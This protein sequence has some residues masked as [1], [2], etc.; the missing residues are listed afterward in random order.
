MTMAAVIC[1]HLM[2][3]GF[4]VHPPKHPFGPLCGEGKLGAARLYLGRASEWLHTDRNSEYLVDIKFHDDKLVMLFHRDVYPCY[5]CDGSGW[6]S[7]ETE[8]C[9]RCSGN[10]HSTWRPVYLRYADP[11]MFARLY[12]ALRARAKTHHVKYPSNR[13]SAGH[14]I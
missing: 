10:G 11:N 12:N 5:V 1:H 3:S 8:L 9:P 4:D 6:I 13:S 7:G 14:L 2:D